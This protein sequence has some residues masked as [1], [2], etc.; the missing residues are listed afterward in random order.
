MLNDKFL[1]DLE[2]YLNSGKLEEDF[3]Y[4]EEQ[5]RLE[6]LDYLE[7]LMDLAEKADE[8]ATRLIFKNSQLGE[9]FGTS[10]DK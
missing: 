9:M 6:M 8:V 2:D 10:E 4:S 3:E 5:R 7:R 1:A